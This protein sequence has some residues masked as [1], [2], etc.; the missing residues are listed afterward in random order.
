MTMNTN[1][2]AEIT[3]EKYPPFLREE[4]TIRAH[5][6]GPDRKLKFHVLLDYLQDIAATHAELL[7]VG[8]SALTEKG[9]LWVL[10]RMK[11]H[12]SRY[13]ACDEKIIVKTYP[14]GVSSLF[15]VREYFISNEKGENL[16]KG[17]SFWLVID[18]KTFRPLKAASFLP[19]GMPVNEE[20]PRYYREAGKIERKDIPCDLSFTVR[21]G[22]IDMNRHLNNAVFAK[23]ILDSLCKSR[24]DFAS[25]KEIQLNFVSSGNLG[26]DLCFGSE[27]CNDR[28][29]YAH[30]LSPDGRKCYI[31]AE[32]ILE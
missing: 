31:Q 29:F 7:D 15:A 8:L 17:T 12:I 6:C 3:A 27:I 21:H 14:S 9:T 19:S 13:P 25:V 23:N 24:N 1:T 30:A 22:D 5:E 26:E 32:G 16:V 28:T 20:L 10:S 4:H 2:H 18:A 11:L